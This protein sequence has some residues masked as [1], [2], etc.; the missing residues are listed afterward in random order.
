MIDFSS[1]D[2]IQLSFSYWFVNEGSDPDPN[3]SLKILFISTNQDSIPV[4]SISVSKGQWKKFQ[5]I[6]FTPRVMDFSLLWKLGFTINDDKAIY[7]VEAGIDNLIINLY[8]STTPVVDHYG[9]IPSI[10]LFHNPAENVVSISW[11]DEW[12]VESINIY[13][14]TGLLLKN[15]TNTINNFPLPISDIPRGI[16]IISVVNAGGNLIASK[17][18]FKK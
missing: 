13:S 18:L 5:P 3:D 8:N 9:I 15:F 12:D 10:Q 16:Y 1:T 11:P 7:L 14:I 4:T 2:S 6:I 17:K